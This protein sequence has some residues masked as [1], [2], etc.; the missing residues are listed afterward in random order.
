MSTSASLG[1]KFA[2]G[3]FVKLTQSIRGVPIAGSVYEVTRH[4]PAEGDGF[5]YRLRSLDGRIERVTL[6]SQLTAS[7]PPNV[8]RPA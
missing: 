4:M 7:A 1:H 6:E 2:V 3:S 5:Q 8:A